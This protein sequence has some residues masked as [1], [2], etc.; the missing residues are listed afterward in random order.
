M[1]AVEKLG[2]ILS[3][4]NNEFENNGV[5]NPGVYQDGNTLHFLY[6]AIQKGNL[7]TIGYAKTTDPLKIVEKLNQP[8]I[9]IEFDYEKEGMEDPKIVKIDDTFYMTYIAYDGMNK[10]G[11]LATSKDLITFEKQGIITPRITYHEYDCLINSCYNDLNPK[12]YLFYQLFKEIGLGNDS[13]RF[14]RIRALALFPRKIKGK[15]ALLLS[16]YPGIQI[17]YFDDF[18]DLNLTFWEEYFENLIDQIV[19]GPKGIYE[20]N[21][22]GVGCVPIETKEGWLLIYYGAQET[23][24][25]IWHHIKA[26]LLDID[27]PKRV[28]SRLKMPLFSP[29]KL[30][31]QKGQICD[32]VFPTGHS[33]IDND[34]YIYYGVA[35]KFIAVTS[36]K[37]NG[38]LLELRQARKET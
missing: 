1:I 11:A 13:L 36:V 35:N 19:L 37:L 12:Y 3:P 31:Q 6:R 30:L 25:G 29:Q 28:L 21:Y 27:N 10:M 2:I 17:V 18:K 9:S 20:V 23:P 34:I 33:I 24:T 16:I 8:L 5:L 7:S 4:T 38:L 26:A 22:V 15:F 14:L 32:M